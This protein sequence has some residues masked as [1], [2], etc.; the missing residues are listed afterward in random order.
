MSPEFSEE[1]RKKIDEIVAHYP[2]KQ[3]AIL[4]LL[5][6]TQQEFGCI[7]PDS[8]KRI[9]DILGLKPIR[10]REVLTFYTMLNREPVGKYHIQACSNLSCSLL[11]AEKLVDYLKEKLGIEPGQTTEDRKFTLSLVE[12]LG[13]CEQAPCMMV[14]F[15][16]FGNLDKKKIDKILDGLK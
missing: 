7:S 5:H 4:P 9:A 6:I 8:E 11:G 12:C 10:V 16:Y 3:A 13:A 15:D 2:Q 14:N 1:T